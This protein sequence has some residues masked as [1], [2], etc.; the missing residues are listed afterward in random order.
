MVIIVSLSSLSSLVPLHRIIDLPVSLS[1]KRYRI[2][3]EYLCMLLSDY[4]N[5]SIL[6]I[7]Y[8]LLIAK[9]LENY[10]RI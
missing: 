4:K 9:Y 3:I 5:E 1:F 2:N 7:F 8:I 10:S 6:Y